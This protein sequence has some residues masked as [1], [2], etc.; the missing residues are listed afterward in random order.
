MWGLTGHPAPLPHSLWFS[1]PCCGI[2]ALHSQTDRWAA[3]VG[4]WGPEARAALV[5]LVQNHASLCVSLALL[6]CQMDNSGALGAFPRQHT[7]LET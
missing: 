5:S 4:T 3:E 7:A 1:R 2:A 6:S